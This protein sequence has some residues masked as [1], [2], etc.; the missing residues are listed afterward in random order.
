MVDDNISVSKAVAYYIDSLGSKPCAVN[1]RWLWERYID[2][3]PLT[4]VST[5]STQHVNDYVKARVDQGLAPSTIAYHLRLIKQGIL[6]AEENGYAGPRSRVKWK[7]PKIKQKTRYLTEDEVKELKH[8]C[9]EH[10]RIVVEG[11]L[12]TGCRWSE[13]LGLRWS[14]IDF[15]ARAIKVWS[16]KT[17]SER[18]VPIPEALFETLADSYW[19]A[20]HPAW[21]F[22]RVSP[23]HIADAIGVAKINT[24]EKVERYGKATIH[25]LRHT[26]ASRLLQ[27]GMSLKEVSVLLGHKSVAMT[28]RY[29]HLDAVKTGEK[30]RLILDGLNKE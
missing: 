13:L 2:H 12:A 26:Y 22:P 10:E 5:W 14:D 23:R 24:P 19:R 7:S 3:D 6:W 4:W 18:R 11:L 20:K 29:A 28:E 15:E 17:D 9:T 16:S 8:C 1:Y 25:S 27:A 30:A 21:P